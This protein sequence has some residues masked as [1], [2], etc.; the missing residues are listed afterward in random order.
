MIC[1]IYVW[2]VFYHGDIYFRKVGVFCKGSARREQKV[3]S[4]TLCRA[5]AYLIAKLVHLSRKCGNFPNISAFA[6]ICWLN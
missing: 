6:P 3:S 4:L 2:S 5:A 1:C